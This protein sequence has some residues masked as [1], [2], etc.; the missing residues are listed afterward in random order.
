MDVSSAYTYRLDWIVSFVAVA[1]EGGFSA[2]AK[3]QHRSQPRVSAHVGE[4]ERVLGVR[5]FDRAVHPPSLTPEGR[6]LLPHAEEVIS[7]LAVFSDVAAGTGNAV[8]GEVRVGMYPS[9]A[10]SLYPDLVRSLHQDMP[11][12]TTVLRERDTLTLEQLLVNGDIDLAVRPILPL[13]RDDRLS[14]R[15]LWREPLVAV[16]PE[17]HPWAGRPELPLAQLAT[18]ALVTI[19]EPDGGTRQFE[20]NLAFAEAGLQ[21]TIAFQTNQ[22]QTLAAL[23]RSGLGIGVTNAL[24]MTVANC[25]GVELVPLGGTNVER[26]VAVWWHTGRTG[27]AATML[28]RDVIAG[29]PPPVVL[30]AAAAL[31]TDDE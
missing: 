18:C 13:A 4:L 6:A 30:A 14:Y 15:L 28:A 9:A 24:A 29:L 11:S 31:P 19:G 21:P 25:E 7:R 12:V 22:P 17:G 1:H 26:R 23:V 5:L 2:A 3:A 16:V 20:T 10:A 27:S 8:R